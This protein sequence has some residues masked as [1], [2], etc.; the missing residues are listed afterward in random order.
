[1]QVNLSYSF[2]TA[3]DAFEYMINGNRTV[4]LYSQNPKALV[5]EIKKFYQK[6]KTYNGTVEDEELQVL[7]TYPYRYRGIVGCLGVECAEITCGTFK[8][9]ADKIALFTDWNY[10]V[11]RDMTLRKTLCENALGDLAMLGSMV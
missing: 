10:T 11:L 6:I 2:K 9:N 8:E 5:S 4:E 1:M 3:E 7:P